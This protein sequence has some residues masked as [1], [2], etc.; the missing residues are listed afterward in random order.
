M[1][2]TLFATFLSTTCLI[3]VPVFADVT[4]E[5]VWENYQSMMTSMGMDITAEESREGDTLVV[6]NMVYGMDIPN[7]TGPITSTSTVPEIRFQALSGGKVG[8][9]YAAPITSISRVPANPVLDMP[10][11]ET[12]VDMSFGGVT[13]VSGV[14]NDM[15]YTMDGSSMTMKSVPAMVEGVALQPGVDMSIEGIVGSYTVLRDGDAMSSDMD[16][17]AAR[18]T[19]GF[20]PFET[21]G[22]TV[23]MATSATDLRGSG[24]MSFSGAKGA[25]TFATIIG[26]SSMDIE[27]SSGPSTAMIKVS[28]DEAGGDME[29]TST[30]GTT[31]LNFTLG[32][33]AAG[34]KINAKDMLVSVAGAQIPGQQVQFGLGS[35]TTGVLFPLKAADAPQA[36]ELEIGLEELALPDLAWMIADPTN[37]LPHDPATLKLHF[38]GTLTNKMDL[39]DLKAL[40]NMGPNSPSPMAV[41]TVEI[42]EI[43]LSLAGATIAGTGAGK[44]LDKEPAVPGGMPPFAG[45]MSLNLK[46]VTDLINKLTAS[47]ILPQDQSMM[48]QMMLG[49]F[50]LPGDQEGELVS[51]LEMTEDGAI[52]ANGQPLPF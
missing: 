42:P 1:R 52:L 8:I 6:R 31:T 9:E 16:F 26:E 44:F 35:M 20:E 32:G 13:E 48:A 37:Q 47:G 45:T 19:Y 33:G 27:L 22:T 21:E 5:E 38:A 7:P 41:N 49:M 34:Y 50:T 3:G 39:F 43:F 51:D 10:G 4:P 18:M 29:L 25:D 40:E 11:Y 23:E 2:S 30:S 15:R 36:Y 24:T 17:T 14:K 12:R 46:G 28:G